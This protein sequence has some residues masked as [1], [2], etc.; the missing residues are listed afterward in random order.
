MWCECGHRLFASRALPSISISAHQTHKFHNI[1][2]FQLHHFTHTHGIPQNSFGYQ[3]KK[4]S[5]FCFFYRRLRRCR[6][7][8]S[9]VCHFTFRAYVCQLI[10]G[11]SIVLV[12]SPFHIDPFHSQRASHSESLSFAE[13]HE[14]SEEQNL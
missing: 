14:K 6:R 7:S 13:D 3:Q 2:D 12:R 9:N 1:F 10:D 4:S 8:F 5:F 11:G